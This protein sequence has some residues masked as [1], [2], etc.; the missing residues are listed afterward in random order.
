MIKVLILTS[1]NSRHKYFVESIAKI[2]NVVGLI[3]DSKKN[4][5]DKAK[6]ESDKVLNHFEKL[7]ETEHFFFGS[8]LIPENIEKME[9]ANINDDHVL[10]WAKQKK[11]DAVFLFGTDILKDGWLNCF[12]NRIVN[13]H[14]GL[15]PFYRGTA[16]LFWPIYHDEIECVGTTIHIATEKVDAGGILERVKP[17]LNVG[18]DYYIINYKTIKKSIDQFPKIALSYLNGDIQPLQQNI[19][20]SKLYKRHDFNED[21]LTVALKNVGKSGLTSEHL[22]IIKSSKKCNC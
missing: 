11:A 16:T 7:K 5:Y 20:K 18:D 19:E 1:S 15:S 13:L 14:L 21:R 3:T 8:A 9:V 4:Y 12:E 10:D 17:D 6:N 2:F 22:E